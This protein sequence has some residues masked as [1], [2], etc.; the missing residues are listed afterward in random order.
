MLFGKFR[1]M[2]NRIASFKQDSAMKRIMSDPALQAQIIDLNQQQ[3]Y[4]EGVQADGTPT[5]QYAR[6]TKEYYKP[7]AA[8][9]GRDGR[10]DH[11]TLKDTGSLYASMDVKA[12]KEGI[13]LSADDPNG[14]FEKMDLDKALG[15]TGE[16]KGDVLPQIQHDFINEF[17]KVLYK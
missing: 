14:V 17:K 12:D 5:G 3:L 7:L 6:A 10:T 13:T 11:V 16:S 4:E 15:L 2:R 8:A 9:E 1:R